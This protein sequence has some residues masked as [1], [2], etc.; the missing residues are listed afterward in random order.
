GQPATVALLER[1]MRLGFREATRS[2][3]SF[4]ASDLCVPS[5]KEAIV[6]A[7]Q[8]EADLLVSRY[9]DGMLSERERYERVTRVW[10]DAT[11]AVADGL[12][13][14]LARDRRADQPINPIHAMVASGARGSAS[15]IGQLAGMRGTMRR[16][17]GEVLETPI[18]ASFREGL[19][20]LE[21]FN[22]T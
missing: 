10:E 17:S 6:A 21:Y 18:K 8:R 7:A 9:E 5:D 3:L 1:L 13:A 14:A 19:S 11:H 15:Q 20:V 4:A 2:G 12:M 16:P 22:S